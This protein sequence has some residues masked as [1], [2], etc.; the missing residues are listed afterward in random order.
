[1]NILN[2]VNR[3]NRL[4]S[5]NCLNI[6]YLFTITYLVLNDGLIYYRK[7]IRGGIYVIDYSS[8]GG[9]TWNYGIVQLRP[10]EDTIIINIDDGEVGYRHLI[11]DGAY[12]IDHELTALGFEGVENT[13]W[14]NVYST[15]III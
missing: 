15:I 9:I 2:S 4:N 11:R 6:G 3:S 14:E 12:V 1:M 5:S 8:D 7:G 13:D 10:D